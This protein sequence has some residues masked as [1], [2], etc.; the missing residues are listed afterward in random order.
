ILDS[1]PD[2]IQA[3]QEQERQDGANG[4]TADQRQGH[5]A[6]E[7]GEGQRNEGQYRRQRRQNDGAGTLYSGFNHG[8]IGR[9]T[10][11]P[12]GLDLLNQNQGIAHQD[13]RQTNQPQNRRKAKG[14]LEN[15]QGGHAANQAQGGGQEHHD[16]VRERTYLNHDNQQHQGNHDREDGQQ[17][18]IGL[19]GLGGDAAHFDQVAR[20]QGSLQGGKLLHHP[21]S[22]FCRLHVRSN[23]S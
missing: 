2:R 22:H 21:V 14:L 11:S 9:G 4:C 6:P 5:G 20:G 19:L 10:F 16:H 1:I 17:R 8:I 7:H 3:G 12:V 23:I 18:V 15:Q 13:P